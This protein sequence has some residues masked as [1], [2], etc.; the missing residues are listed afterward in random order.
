M[1][2]LN[3]IMQRSLLSSD[4]PSSSALPASCLNAL[5]IVRKMHFV[6]TVILDENCTRHSP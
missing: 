5:L 4:G 1:P 3:S 2:L 6:I